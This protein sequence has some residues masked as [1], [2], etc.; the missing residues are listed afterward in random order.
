MLALATFWSSS[1]ALISRPGWSTT[2]LLAFFRLASP[3][4]QALIAFASVA[5]GGKITI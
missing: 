5:L 3:L 1:L 2:R 4:V